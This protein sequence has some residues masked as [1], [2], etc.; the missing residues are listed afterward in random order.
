MTVASPLARQYYFMWLFFP[1]TVLVHRAAYDERPA[2]RL[3]TWLALAAAGLLMC[4]SFPVFPND[5]QAFGNNFVA[6]IIMGAALSWHILHPPITDKAGSA[7][8]SELQEREMQGETAAA[9][10]G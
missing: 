7:P 1:M 5:L 6:T 8:A 9:A 3:W 10:Q 4:L 2:V